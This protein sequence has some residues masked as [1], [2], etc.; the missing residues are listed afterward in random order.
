MK[1]G[2]IIKTHEFSQIKVEKTRMYTYI[3]LIKTI[4]KK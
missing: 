2:L 1:P 4:Y 3:E